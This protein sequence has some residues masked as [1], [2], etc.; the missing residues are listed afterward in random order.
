MVPRESSLARSRKL[1][2]ERE[3]V[4]DGSRRRA[5]QKLTKFTLSQS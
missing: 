4:A 5:L 1:G 2:E 3:T